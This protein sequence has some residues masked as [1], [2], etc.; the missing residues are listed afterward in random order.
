MRIDAHNLTT[1]E[2][3][4]AI[5]AMGFTPQ[6][7]FGQFVIHR[8]LRPEI[9]M[10][11]FKRIFDNI[12]PAMPK[13][14]KPTFKGATHALKETFSDQ[15]KLVQ[16]IEENEHVVRFIDEHGTGSTPRQ[17]IESLTALNAE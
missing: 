7:G 10:P 12:A 13:S 17:F 8:D 15:V 6:D 11:E 3:V 2:L 4:A 9:S 1:E 5:K 16:V 14:D